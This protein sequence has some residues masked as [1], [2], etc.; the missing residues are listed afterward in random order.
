[1]FITGTRFGE[2]VVKYERSP[3]QSVHYAHIS[4]GENQRESAT[5]FAEA[6]RYSLENLKSSVFVV[7]EVAGRR[8]ARK[9][10]ESRSCSP[11]NLKSSVFVAETLAGLRRTR[12]MVI[13]DGERIR[14]S[15]ID[16]DLVPHVDMSRNI[17]EGDIRCIRKWN[18]L[19]TYLNPRVRGSIPTEGKNSTRDGGGEDREVAVP[20]PPKLVGSGLLHRSNVV[21]NRTTIKLV[22]GA[23]DRTPR[24]FK[25]KTY[26]LIGILVV[27]NT[28]GTRA[29]VVDLENTGE[30]IEDNSRP[31]KVARVEETDAS[32]SRRVH[33][34]VPMFVIPPAMGSVELVKKSTIVISDAEKAIMDDMSPEALKN[35]LT[36]AMVSAFKLMEITSYLDGKECKY[37]EERDAVKDEANLYKQK[38]EQAKVNHVAYKE[39]FV[40]QAGLLTKLNEKEEEAA[41]LTTEKEELA[42]QVASLTTEKKTLEEKVKELE[43]RPCSSAPAANPEQALVDPSGE[44]S[45]FTRAALIAKIF[46]LDSQQLNI[47]NSGFDN[48]VA[49]LMVLNPSVDLLAEGASELKEVHDGLIVYPTP[50]ED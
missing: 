47:A 26:E 17:H 31:S 42:G 24:R 46:E 40:L 35:E 18:G 32:A 19:N 39:K 15:D 2:F 36:D 49:Q 43:S 5:E 4:P 27:L 16:G 11:E 30:H 38:L 14:V 25:R 23:R 12:L 29:T 13:K 10:A 28:L 41:R 33:C 37:L 3:K 44:Y 6:R 50:D 1:M 9:L 20:G 45:G 21:C 22:D 8:S 48:V 34:T 7:E